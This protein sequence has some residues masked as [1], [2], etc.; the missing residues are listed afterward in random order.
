VLENL[1]IVEA[2]HDWWSAYET[3]HDRFGEFGHC[4]IYQEI[5]TLAVTLRFAENVGHGLGLQV[6]QGNDTDSYGATAGSLLG[7]LFG[8]AAFD[9]RWIVPF[10]DEIHLGLALVHERSLSALADRMA[11]L[12]MRRVQG[13]R[14]SLAEE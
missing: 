13:P 8:R 10:H 2:A 9:E 3:V 11:Q 1:E 12:P 14:S 7:A 6:C 5:G 4:R